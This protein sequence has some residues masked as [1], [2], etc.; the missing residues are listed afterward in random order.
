MT[1]VVYFYS[2]HCECMCTSRTSLDPWDVLVLMNFWQNFTERQIV[3]SLFSVVFHGLTL[4]LPIQ[5]SLSVA[6]ELQGFV[7]SDEHC[8]NFRKTSIPP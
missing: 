2:E 1:Y 3:W 7:S 5:T 6:P 8:Q 4:I